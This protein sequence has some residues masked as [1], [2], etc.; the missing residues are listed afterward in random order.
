MTTPLEWAPQNH[1][2][3]PNTEFDGLNVLAIKTIFKGQELTLDYAHF[4]DEN[5]EPFHCQCGSPSCRGE[6]SGI[7]HNSLTTREV[8]LQ[9]LNDL[10]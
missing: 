10:H 3:E 7:L 2:C 5:M 4:S 1:S 9:Q 6:I 8:N